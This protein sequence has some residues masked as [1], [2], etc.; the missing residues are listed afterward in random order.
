MSC[1]REPI[2]HRP[3]ET[4]NHLPGCSELLDWC[5]KVDDAFDVFRRSEFWPVE[6]DTNNGEDGLETRLGEALA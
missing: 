5:D 4:R 1:V 3:L 6:K 2:R